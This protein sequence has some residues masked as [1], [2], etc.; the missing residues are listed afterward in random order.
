MAKGKKID[1]LAG[2]K[3]LTVGSQIGITGVLVLQEATWAPRSANTTTSVWPS[4]TWPPAV[5]TRHL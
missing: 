1:S 5:P 4:K 2:L 3:G